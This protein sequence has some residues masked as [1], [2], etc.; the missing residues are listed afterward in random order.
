MLVQKNLTEKNQDQIADSF[1]LI[2]LVFEIIMYPQVS[3]RITCRP[4]YPQSN[5]YYEA[6]LRGPHKMLP[7]VC[8]SVHLSVYPSY[9]ITYLRFSWNRKAI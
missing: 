2:G 4:F 6:I 1:E 9:H 5:Y 3:P 7:P 8:L